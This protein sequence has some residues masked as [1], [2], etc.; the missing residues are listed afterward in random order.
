MDDSERAAV[1]AHERRRVDDED[2]GVFACVIVC[3]P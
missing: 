2:E 3:T 1:V